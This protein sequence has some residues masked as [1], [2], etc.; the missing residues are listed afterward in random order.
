ME[1]NDLS[2]KKVVCGS[3]MWDCTLKFSESLY[4][5]RDET[6]IMLLKVVKEFSVC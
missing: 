4:S 5:N 6:R 1:E 2:L 3:D